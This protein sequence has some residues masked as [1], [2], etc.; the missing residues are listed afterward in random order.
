MNKMRCPIHKGII[1]HKNKSKTKGWCAECEKW[2]KLN[3]EKEV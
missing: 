1:L 3:T 2:H